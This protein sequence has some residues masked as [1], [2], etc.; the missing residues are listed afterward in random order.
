MK[1]QPPMD[2]KHNFKLGFTM[3]LSQLTRGRVGL[4]VTGN[5]QKEGGEPADVVLFLE[6]AP[7]GPTVT[8]WDPRSEPEAERREGPGGQRGAGARQRELVLPDPE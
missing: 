1:T 4:G 8:F 2:E 5:T 3:L 6:D 7:S